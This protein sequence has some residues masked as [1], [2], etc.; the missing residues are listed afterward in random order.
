MTSYTSGVYI[1]LVDGLLTLLENCDFEKLVSESH[2][3]PVIEM[4]GSATF[5]GCRF[6]GNSSMNL[7]AVI[8]VNG[9]LTVRDCRFEDNQARDGAFHIQ[10]GSHGYELD[11]DSSRIQG[12]RNSI[13]MVDGVPASKL[14][15]GAGNTEF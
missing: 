12:G 14:I 7:P 2:D 3:Y 15:Y 5:R 13:Y 11:I 4:S 10:L 8:N 6:V 9:P 1:F